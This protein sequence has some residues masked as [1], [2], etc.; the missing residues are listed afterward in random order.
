MRIQT[1]DKTLDFTPTPKAQDTAAKIHAE[2]LSN[3]TQMG[4]YTLTSLPTFDGGLS[5][6]YAGRTTL[7]AGHL[8]SFSVDADGILTGHAHAMFS[9]DGTI[10]DFHPITGGM[11]HTRLVRRG[12]TLP[13]EHL[14][15]IEASQKRA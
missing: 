13:A 7:S 9:E 8:R 12:I 10:G 2:I 11:I 4:E 5:L 3:A 1:E 6:F 15:L 14:A